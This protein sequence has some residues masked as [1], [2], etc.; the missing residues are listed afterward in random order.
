MTLA[1]TRELLGRIFDAAV[2]AA[3]PSTCLP[4]HLPATPAEGRIIILAAGKAAGSMTAAAE[5]FYLDQHGV[6]PARLSGI[7][8]ARIGYGEA[9]RVVEMVEAGHPVPGRRRARRGAPRA[10]A[11]GGRD[12]EDLVLV[13]ISGGGSANWIAP[14]GALTLAEKQQITRA[15]LRSGASIGEINTLRK[16]LSPHQGRTPGARRRIPPG[17]VTL[18]ISDVPHDDPS[19][20]ASGPTVPDPTTMADA[21]AIVAKYRLDLPPS[22]ARAARRRCGGDAQARRRRLRALRVRASWRGR[23]RRWTRPTSRRAQAGYEPHRARRGPRGRGPDS[24][25]GAGPPGA[26]AAAARAAAR[27]SSPEASSP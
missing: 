11:G 13:L 25:A 22:A 17:C 10:G 24:R 4:P 8:V 27:R 26:G 20:I 14:A 6:D 9:T 5:R 1:E 2:A 23:R 16:R 15:L 7:A 19:T 12:R 18:A 3:H 21:R